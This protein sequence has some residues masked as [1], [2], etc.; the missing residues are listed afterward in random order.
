[1]AHQVVDHLRLAGQQRRIFLP[2]PGEKTFLKQRMRRQ[3]IV[4]KGVFHGRFYIIS[5]LI[6]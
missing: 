3:K 2:Q 1:M 5:I 6:I 4:V